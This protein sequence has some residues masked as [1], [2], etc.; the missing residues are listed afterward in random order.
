MEST[1]RKPGQAPSDAIVLFDG[2]DM[3]EWLS[4]KTGG[5]SP[6]VIKDGALES[7]KKAGYVRTKRSFGDCQLHIEFATPK[8]V[9]GDSQGRG[10]SGV[11]LMGKYEI[12]VLDSFKNPT[13]SDGSAASVYGQAPPLVNACRGPG[14]WQTYDIIFRAPVFKG[15]K[16]VKPATV[17]VIQNGVLVQDHWTIEGGTHHKKRSKYV[18]HEAKLPLKLQDHG[19]PVR[20]RNIW[21]R[22]LPPPE[23][24]KPDT[25]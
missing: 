13:Y 17:T 15:N 21:V 24:I 5:P 14:K 23:N 12:Q 4:D 20:Y 11:F 18:P 9:Q 16:V 19:N 1:A 8:D 10:N 7:V 6:W 22:E 2:S 25:K 3:D